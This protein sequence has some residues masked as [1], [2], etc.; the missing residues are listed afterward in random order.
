MKWSQWLL[1]LYFLVHV[2]NKGIPQLPVGYIKVGW[3]WVVY[4]R[5]L[6]YTMGQSCIS[7]NTRDVRILVVYLDVCGWIMLVN[8]RYSEESIAILRTARIPIWGGNCWRF[9]PSSR[10]W[11]RISY[12]YIVRWIGLWILRQNHPRWEN[13]KALMVYRK[14]P[15]VCLLGVHPPIAKYF[16]NLAYARRPTC[17]RL[18]IPLRISHKTMSLLLT[19]SWRVYSDIVLSGICVKGAS[20][21]FYLSIS[22]LR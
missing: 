2:R 21:Y 19:F 6:V 1:T 9:F 22:V 5:C 12:W 11:F 15:G 8:F 20:I 18:Y 17:G 10:Q 14:R 7:V 4:R 3:A 13:F 16:T